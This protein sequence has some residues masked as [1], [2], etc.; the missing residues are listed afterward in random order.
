MFFKLDSI[1]LL[2]IDCLNISVE[3]HI[4]NGLPSFTIVGLPDKA[5][6]ESRMRVRAAI[7]NSGFKFPSKKIIINL[8][9]ADIK[10]EGPFYD[11]PIAF[12]LLVVS[13]QIKHRDILLLEKSSFIG[14]LSLDGMLNPVRG[15]ISMTEA[16]IKAGKKL[17][18]IP[19]Q[20][21][22]QA[23]IIKNIHSQ[24]FS[25]IG[26]KSLKEAVFLVCN[27]SELKKRTFKV[28]HKKILPDQDCD[29]AT[30]TNNTGTDFSFIKGQLKAKRAVEVA[31]AGMHNIMLVGPP[32]AGKTMIAQAINSILP[33]LDETERI[34]VTKI[35]SILKN[36]KGGLIKR[37]PFRNPHHTITRAGLTGGGIIPKPGEVS[38]AHRGVLF[39]DEFSQ[40]PRSL[41]EDLRQPIENK[42]IIISRNSYFYRFPCSFMLVLATNP[43]SCGYNGDKKKECKCSRREILKY[44]GKISGPIFDR[45]D[46][47][48]SMNRLEENDYLD[49]NM[50]FESSSEVKKRI[51]KC[52]FI[53]KQR[54]VNDATGD[55]QYFHYNSEAGTKFINKWVYENKNLNSLIKESV[56]KFN[57]SSRAV[58]AL[59]KISRTIADLEEIPDIKDSHFMEAL[60]YRINFNYE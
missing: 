48:V 3:I 41:I 49:F 2:G 9:P 43:C 13:G 23:S 54:Y 19:E 5:V 26:C 34:E 51:Y 58:S 12:S 42:E 38:L 59:I 20:N 57:L 10:K 30:E 7:I 11:F 18:F 53:Q 16:V 37:R 25:I 50:V 22:P 1:A 15:I 56:K 29:P 14:E 8:S 4:S 39:L 17:F 45:I 35:Y 24:D 33:D 6:N 28:L 55:K 60:S 36:I 46:I 52:H 32:G 47:I 27:S 31:A 21:M 40:F 44:W